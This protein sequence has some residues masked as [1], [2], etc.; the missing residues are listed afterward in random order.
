VEANT[1]AAENEKESLPDEQ[2]MGQ[3]NTFISAAHDTMSSSLA[4]MLHSLAHDLP[5]QRRLREEL[6]QARTEFG[7][8]DF[9]AVTT[10]RTSPR[11]HRI[12]AITIYTDVAMQPSSMQSTAR[13]SASTPLFPSRTAR[14]PLSSLLRTQTETETLS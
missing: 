13:P 14:E 3:M 2:V 9:H 8:L 10:L 7:D 6:T 1:T 5:R 11:H 4:R 12:S